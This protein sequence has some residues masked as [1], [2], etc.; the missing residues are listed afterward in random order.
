[1]GEPDGM[2]KLIFDEEERLIAGHIYGAHAADLI[3]E[4]VPMIAA[5]YTLQQLRETIHAH[6]TLG[7]VILKAA[8]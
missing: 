4:L 3:Q 5:G 7:E 8:H 6:P 1:M 2:V